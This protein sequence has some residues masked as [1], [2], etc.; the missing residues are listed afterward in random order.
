VK[1][2]KILIPFTAAEGGNYHCEPKAR[3]LWEQKVLDALD[4]IMKI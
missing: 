3:I 4:A 2:Q 1:S